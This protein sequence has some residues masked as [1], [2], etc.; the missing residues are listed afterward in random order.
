MSF[1]TLRALA[2][3][4][5]FALAAAP[6]CETVE[7]GDEQNATA[8]T[9]RFET[10]TGVD[11][12]T[13]FQLLAKNGE[14]ILRSEGYTSLSGAKK[15][16]TSVKKNGMTET[17]YKVLRADNGEFYFNLVASNGK[18][19]ATSELYSSE[20]GAD[21]AV[22]AVIAALQNPAS[23]PAEE[24]GPRF[25]TF[26]GSDKKTYFRLRAA[27]GQIVLQSQGYSSKSA[28]EKGIASVKNNGDDAAQFRIVGGAEGQHSFVLVAGNGKTIAHGEMYASKSNA[29]RGADRVREII[30]EMTNA[31]SV[32]DAE[33]QAEVEKASEGLTYTSESDFPFS[34]VSA[35]LSS[36]T[37]TDQV[38]RDAFEAA[39]DADPAADKPMQDLV[40][41]ERSWQDWKDAG[42][43]C[44]DPEDPVMMELCS[45]MRNLE[46][47]LES[48]LEDIH[49]CYFGG[50]GQ[51]GDVEGIGVSIFI[52]G[53]S[54]E[55]S[56]V[57][58]RTIAIW[59]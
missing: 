49:V 33:I 5:L 19:I 18:I 7:V 13:Y 48:N 38:V 27:N 44:S 52:V 6:A 25:E 20:S 10:F 39:V 40:W 43:N 26:K 55:G 47:V 58:V 41:M 22:D 14:K 36:A 17:R 53:R 50:K 29:I 56:L 4:L 45:K 32:T 42:H 46:Q 21:R 51:V 1:R 31:G 28:A 8:N 35:P 16:I 12:Q 3:A 59:T 2:A 37:I 23:A 30:R 54:P 9:G 34:F 57:G 11:G 24:S 15:G